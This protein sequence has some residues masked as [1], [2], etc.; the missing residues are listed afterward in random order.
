MIFEHFVFVFCKIL[1]HLL[2]RSAY[3][4]LWKMYGMY[5]SFRLFD[6][7]TVMWKTEKLLQLYLCC[8]FTIILVKCFEL[9]TSQ[10]LVLAFMEWSKK[11][12]LPLLCV[13]LWF[14]RIMNPTFTDLVL[15]S[16]KAKSFLLF[17]SVID[18][19]MVGHKSNINKTRQF[20]SVWKTV[21]YS[22]FVTIPEN[23]FLVDQI[24]YIPQEQWRGI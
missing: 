3:L 11:C 8:H 24:I 1:C 21:S 16:T 13:M 18:R 14:L 20:S 5:W 2:L 22:S 6:R 7:K 17:T 4:W 9:F 19:K 10:F 15:H 12:G 23:K